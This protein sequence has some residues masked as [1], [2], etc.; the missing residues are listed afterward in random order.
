MTDNIL[1]V[2]KNLLIMILIFRLGKMNDLLLEL[3]IEIQPEN[4]LAFIA[5]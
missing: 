2:Y 4:P 5:E 1:P 3:L